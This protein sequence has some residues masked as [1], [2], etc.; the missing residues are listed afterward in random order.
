MTA[1]PLATLSKTSVF[2]A[3]QSLPDPVDV[4]TIIEAILVRAKVERGLADADAG[5]FVDEDELDRRFG[6]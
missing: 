4:E 6:L 1:H 5:R 3:I 2:D